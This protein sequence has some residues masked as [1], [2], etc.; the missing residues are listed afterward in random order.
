MPDAARDADLRSRRGDERWRCPIILPVRYVYADDAI[1]FRTGAGT[2]LRA[3]ESGDVL[4]F[5]VDAYDAET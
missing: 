2:K 5:E 3:A 1:T 4:A